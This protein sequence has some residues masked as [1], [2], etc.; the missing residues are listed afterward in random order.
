MAIEVV[1]RAGGEISA[2]PI[3]TRILEDGSLTGRHV[4][5][6]EVTLPPRTGGPQSE[7]TGTCSLW[8]ES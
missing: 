1:D 8:E 2:G 3:T 4:G 6:L 5:V 7:S